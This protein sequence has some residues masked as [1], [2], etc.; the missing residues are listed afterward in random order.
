M[1]I[2]TNIERKVRCDLKGP[3]CGNCTKS[4]RVCRGYGIQLS[5]PRDGDKKRAMIS[6]DT[7]ISTRQSSIAKGFLNTSSWDVSLSEEL[8]RGRISGEDY[9][10]SIGKLLDTDDDYSSVSSYH[11][12]SWPDLPVS[13]G[14]G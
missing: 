6:R 14:Y 4:R 3:R 2:S 8:E 10:L 7:A 13:Y 11:E 9:R 5:W 12:S 1:L